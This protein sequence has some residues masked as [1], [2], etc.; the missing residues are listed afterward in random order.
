MADKDVLEKVQK[1][2]VQMI[3]ELKG[4]TYEERLLELNLP[5]LKLKRKHFDLVYKRQQCVALGLRWSDP[6]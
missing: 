2:A 4:K 6:T 1:R 3:T 5:S